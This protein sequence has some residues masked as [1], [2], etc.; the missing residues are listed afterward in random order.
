F[1]FEDITRRHPR[2][3]ERHLLLYLPDELL[4]VDHQKES[5]VR[6]LYEFE[7]LGRSSEG[8]PREGQARPFR[9][10]EAPLEL[11]C[12]HRPGEYAD[13]VRKALDYF[14]QGELFETVPGQLFRSACRDLPSAVFTRLRRRNPAPYGAFLNLGEEEYLVAA[15]PEMYLRVEDGRVESCPISG[16]IARGRSPLEDARQIR[17]LLNSEKDLAEL[18]MC[19]DVDRN[20]K[21]RVCEA[22][23]I[24]VLG[25]RQIELYSRLIHTV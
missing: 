19:T 20:D 15:S 6:Y 13:T 14:R 24:R 25:R 4:V 2:D 9:P 22:D 7:A 8:L 3:G 21:A 1:Q 12:Y 11:A 5:A 23:S 16:T 18:S 10:A 17:R